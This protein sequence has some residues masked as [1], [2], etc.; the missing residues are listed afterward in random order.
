M[1]PMLTVESRARRLGRPPAR[2]EPVDHASQVPITLLIA[3]SA[4]VPVVAWVLLKHPPGDARDP[5]ALRVAFAATIATGTGFGVAFAAGFRRLPASATL[6]LAAA[7]IVLSAALAPRFATWRVVPAAADVLAAGAFLQVGFNAM[8]KPRSRSAPQLPAAIAV[9]GLA[10]P[11][12]PL[13]LLVLGGNRLER[14]GCLC[15]C[16]VVQAA[17][18]SGI[19]WRRG[20]L[21]GTGSRTAAARHHPNS[22]RSN[23]RP[24]DFLS[25]EGTGYGAEK[26]AMSPYS[27]RSIA[28]ASIVCLG[29]AIGASTTQA[30]THAATHHK[31][32]KVAVKK[33]KTVKPSSSTKTTTTA[34]TTLTSTST[35][36]TTT[37]TTTPTTQAP[38][39]TAAGNV[40]FNGGTTA[41]WMLNQSATTSRVQSVPD[42][43][44]IAGNA[45]EFT[46]LNTDISP[47]TPTNNPRSQL[48]T[49]YLFQNGQQY[50]ESYE[51]YIPQSFPT[52]T[53]GWVSFGAVAY[54]KPWNGTPPAELEYI[55]G[56]FRFQRNGFGPNPWQIAW[57]MPAT[58]GQWY[59][60][61]WHFDFSKTGWIQLYVNDQLQTLLNGT[62][63]VTQL[64]L[65]M[66]DGSDNQG[67]W[68]SD[69]QL[70]YQHNMMATA[71]VFFKNYKVATTQTAAES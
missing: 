37:T 56:Q 55:N 15:I 29:S 48:V 51:V 28:L 10:I 36:G 49:P 43:A 24:E 6:V 70:Y 18:A 66:I 59:R 7:D 27:L 2:H 39:I 50:W 8:R 52:A 38:S 67:P 65:A 33:S 60:I 47:L 25:L 26:P 5:A 20:A 62:Q 68:F 63:K 40:L 9:V 13:C 30:A 41:G 45:L 64:P 61:T 4:L 54:G 32:H 46:T 23:K 44:G 11:A 3:V 19:A 35:T 12:L 31:S 21:P 58:K 22:I 14:I 17:V 34:T 53:G 71:N 16:A 1:D 69:L 57:T 42:P